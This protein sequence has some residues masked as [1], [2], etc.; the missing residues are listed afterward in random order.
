MNDSI[1]ELLTE[2][3]VSELVIAL[4]LIATIVGVLISQ[5]KRILKWMN[6]WRKDKN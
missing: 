1:M 6:K 4:V 2:V 5:K 3:T